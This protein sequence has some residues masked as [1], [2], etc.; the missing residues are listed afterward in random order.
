MA[1]STTTL[2]KLVD[3]LIFKSLLEFRDLLTFDIYISARDKGW[4][5]STSTTTRANRPFDSNSVAW[6][7]LIKCPSRW[8][9][10]SNTSREHKVEGRLGKRSQTAAHEK[11]FLEGLNKTLHLPLSLHLEEEK[12]MFTENQLG[13]LLHFQILWA[14]K[15]NKI[16]NP[17]Y[18]RRKFFLDGKLIFKI[19]V[20]INKNNLFML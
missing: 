11:Q 9:I 20:N 3:V 18:P 5:K 15:L 14:P 2:T 6:S 19:L 12:W 7:S 17:F 10:N 1:Y 4:D 16:L 13:F 8:T